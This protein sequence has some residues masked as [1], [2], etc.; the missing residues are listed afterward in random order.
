MLT[1]ESALRS[2]HAFSLIK[3]DIK[4]GLGHAYMIVSADEE[5]LD[6]FFT[7]TASAICCQTQDACFECPECLKVLHGNNPDIY[8]LFPEDGMIKVPALD[9]FL[10][11]I[12]IKSFTSKKLYFIHNAD[13]MN[14]Q[15]QNKLLKTLEEP[16]ADSI[17][18]LGVRNE[19]SMLGTIK[20]RTRTV[21]MDLF[22]EETIKQ[23]LINIGCDPAL[24][25]IA[26]AC[27]EGY[28]GKAY[29]IASSQ[30]YTDLYNAS[31][32]IL[33]NLNKSTDIMKLSPTI[34]GQ[35]D[36]LKF[37]DVFSIIIRD[38]MVAKKDESLTLSKHT[39]S[40]I[41]MLANKYSE[42]ALAIILTHINEERKKLALLP[43][44]VLNKSIADDL[45][46]SVLE[47]RY[48]WQQ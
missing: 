1:F 31:F 19:A 2:S 6:E 40:K 21:H 25:E 3:S 39:Q 17:L 33:E 45:L 13:C 8:N 14:L 30:E 28:L 35:K 43:Q 16:P 41:V 23:N 15:A 7:L 22:D 24:S 44:K 38:M 47:A 11:N 18:F 36:L 12:T 48:I 9:A 5:T 37:L 4:N 32:T 46:F 27:S 34:S 10:D 29:K 26:A 20:S 42:K